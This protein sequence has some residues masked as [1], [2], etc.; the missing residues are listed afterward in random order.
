MRGR[1]REDTALGVTIKNVG[2]RGAA[3]KQAGLSRKEFLTENLYV[4]EVVAGN[5]LLCF[6]V[7]PA[8]SRDR[9][10]MTVEIG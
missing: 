4:I 7:K 1:D 9:L 2:V 10:V 6:F 8:E 3:F 5:H